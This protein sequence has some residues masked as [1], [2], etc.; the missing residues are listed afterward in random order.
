MSK[1]RTPDMSKSLVQTDDGPLDLRKKTKA[2][3]D[4]YSSA[5]YFSVVSYR[6]SRHSALF[7]YSV[8]S[9][10]AFFTR[11][12]WVETNRA[13]LVDIDETTTE[14]TVEPGIEALNAAEAGELLT[15]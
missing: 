9:R 11:D 10:F 5:H 3:E 4:N 14:F 15:N 6:F 7:L 13:I 1:Q 12:Q 2:H 8:T